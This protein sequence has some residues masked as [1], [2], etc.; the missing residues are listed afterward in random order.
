M[1][2]NVLICLV[3]A[4][5]CCAGCF[6]NVAKQDQKD[7][8]NIYIQRARSKIDEGEPKAAIALYKQALDVDPTLARA[9]LDLALLLHDA[10]DDYIATIY[11]YRRYIELRPDTEKKKMIENRI[12]LASQSFAGQIMGK[13]YAVNQA[14]VEELEKKN[15]ELTDKIEILERKNA[16]FKDKLLQKK[17]MNRSESGGR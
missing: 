6:E 1:K 2:C 17:E 5:T 13:K 12:R 4:L 7:G 10:G 11:H 15:K 9:H 14:F 8:D 3:M 16:I